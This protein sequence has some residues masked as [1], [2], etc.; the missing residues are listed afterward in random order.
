MSHFAT[1]LEEIETLDPEVDYERIVQL[2]S[3]VDFPSDTAKALEFALFRTFCVPSIADRLN[4]YVGPS[5]AMPERYEET[6]TIVSEI[7]ARGCGSERGLAAIERL[8]KI[9]RRHPIP[10]RDWIYVLSAFICEPIRWIARFGWRPLDEKE[11]LAWFFLVRSVGRALSLD[12]LPD[13]LLE[14][15]QFNREYERDHSRMPRRSIRPSESAAHYP[16][17][18]SLRVC[19]ENALRLRGRIATRLVRLP[20]IAPRLA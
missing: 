10:D 3:G 20:R 6:G 18:G 7:V 17:P 9:R 5:I 11:R 1:V 12:N 19:G 16:A 2:S 13:S 8:R 15:E 14:F 4:R